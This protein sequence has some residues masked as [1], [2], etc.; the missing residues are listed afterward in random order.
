MNKKFA[1]SITAKRRFLTK[2]SECIL[3]I[4]RSSFLTN[5]IN[6]SVI[7]I[8]NVKIENTFKPIINDMLTE[9]LAE[10]NGK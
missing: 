10:N 4:I 1:W 7:Q 5:G 2:F 9:M 6:N 8:I 3:N